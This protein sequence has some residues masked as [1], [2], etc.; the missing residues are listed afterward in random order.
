MSRRGAAAGLLAVAA[1]TGCGGGAPEQPPA[2]AASPA[3]EPVRI[4]AGPTGQTAVL[5]HVYAGRLREA[6]ERGLWVPRSN[7]ARM[8]VEALA[9]GGE[10][11]PDDGPGDR[12]Q[13]RVP[14]PEAGGV[15]AGVRS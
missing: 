13:R 7:S 12:R 3:A 5:A 2:T 9:E 1:L 11:R 10:A 8:R 15:T 6:I 4:A 14:F